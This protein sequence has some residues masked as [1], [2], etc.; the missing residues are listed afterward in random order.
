M[1]QR[2]SV[3]PVLYDIRNSHTSCRDIQQPTCIFRNVHRQP[4]L[5]DYHACSLT[6]NIAA[7]FVE[8]NDKICVRRII[9]FL[10]WLFYYVLNCVMLIATYVHWLIDWL[11]DWLFVIRL[12]FNILQC[13]CFTL[14]LRRATE[15]TNALLRQISRVHVYSNQSGFRVSYLGLLIASETHVSVISFCVVR[16]WREWSIDVNVSF[17]IFFKVSPLTLVTNTRGQSSI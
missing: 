2:Q 9:I 8:Q 14:Y 16:S 17:S 13:M 6:P 1:V 10:I 7:T 11:I 5:L 15:Y 12:L 4:Y 3:R